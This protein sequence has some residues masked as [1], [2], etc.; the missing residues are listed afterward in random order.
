MF[1]ID[2]IH[3]KSLL[4]TLA[5]F[6]VAAQATPYSGHVHE[7]IDKENSTKTDGLILWGYFFD[8][9][10]G[11]T[12]VD[13]TYFESDKHLCKFSARVA[14]WSTADDRYAV[15]LNQNCPPSIIEKISFALS[16]ATSQ[17]GDGDDNSMVV[18]S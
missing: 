4:Q 15:Y 18:F 11:G 1:I 5:T 14:N 9:F 17:T 8:L 12:T 13:E 10:I 7:V 3:M 6:V 2:I 16:W